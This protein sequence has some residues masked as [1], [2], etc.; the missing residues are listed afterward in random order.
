MVRIL[1]ILLLLLFSEFAIGQ[2]QPEWTH[3]NEPIV[4][5]SSP[6]VQDTTSWKL[7]FHDEFNGTSLDTNKW[8]THYPYG[9][10]ESDRTPAARLHTTTPKR[11]AQIYR[12]DK[13][14]V[15]NG[16]LE[17]HAAK[18]KSTYMGVTKT[19]EAGMV[20]SKDKKGFRGYTK[21]EIR[22]KI[23]DGAGFFPAFWMFGSTNEI[24]CFEFNGV[25][26]NRH[27]VGMIKWAQCPVEGRFG[28]ARDYISAI[29][30]SK[31][32]HTFAI[33]HD[34]LYMTYYVDN[35]IVFQVPRLTLLSSLVPGYYIQEPAYP[36]STEGMRVI[37]NLAI[38]A[39]K[40]GNKLHHPPSIFT[41]LPNKMEVDYI[42]VYQR[43]PQSNL[44]DLCVSSISGPNTISKVRNNTY[45]Y[46]G[47]LNIESWSISKNLTIVGED[48][49]LIIVNLDPNSSASDA[50]IKPNFIEKDQPCANSTTKN[51]IIK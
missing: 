28:Q 26:P 51:I 47:D 17:L 43:H 1:F 45:K 14:I 3:Y 35:Q 30:F 48:K 29:D 40:K 42:R 31:D 37:A 8:L 49:N 5:L 24:D 23:P 22:C 38:G 20:H 33:A 39:G 32:F 27:L 25:N 44:T 4:F 13:A 46:E 50:W 10:D 19:H 16:M 11:E 15:N 9:P 36:R 7:V 18:N 21:Y 34:D 6:P 12:D 2:C 41:E